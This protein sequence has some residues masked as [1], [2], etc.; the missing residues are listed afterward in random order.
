MYLLFPL[1]PESILENTLVA[2]IQKERE[3]G[4]HLPLSEDWS[5]IVSMKGRVG[6]ILKDGQIIEQN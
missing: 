2:Y 5:S 6:M 4:E 1:E 3:L